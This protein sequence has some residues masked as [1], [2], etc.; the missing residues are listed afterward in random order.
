[1]SRLANTS[2]DAIVICANI[3]IVVLNPAVYSLAHRGVC[4]SIIGLGFL[5]TRGA[6]FDIRQARKKTAIDAPTNIF[7]FLFILSPFFVLL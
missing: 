7:V 3:L 2:V 6:L 5:T 1:M 4:Q